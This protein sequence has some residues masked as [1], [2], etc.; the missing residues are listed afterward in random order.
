M[1]TILLAA[2]LFLISMPALA[3]QDQPPAPA[4][5]PTA[6]TDGPTQPIAKYEPLP[7]DPDYVDTGDDT[8]R[9]HQTA[10]ASEALRQM[11]TVVGN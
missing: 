11:L 3:Q 7:L 6:V 1:K 9:P 5:P 2:R 10:D 8:D 4:A